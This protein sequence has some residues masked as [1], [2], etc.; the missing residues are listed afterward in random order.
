MIML[1][2]RA[3]LFSVHILVRRTV[4]LTPHIHFIYHFGVSFFSDILAR[5][6][7]FF[8]PPIA[9]QLKQCPFRSSAFWLTHG[10]NPQV[11]PAPS[12]SWACHHTQASLDISSLFCTLTFFFFPFFFW[13]GT[14]VHTQFSIKYGYSY[15]SVK[16]RIGRKNSQAK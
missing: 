15:Q 11:D 16:S 7:F 10:C 8:C 5:R 9:C 12:L 6:G 13:H 3:L 2:G 4:Q 1:G 14:D